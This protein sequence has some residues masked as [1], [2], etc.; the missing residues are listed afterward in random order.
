MRASRA[1][2]VLPVLLVA[3]ACGSS[4]SSGSPP[5]QGASSPPSATP[6]AIAP[7]TPNASSSAAAA[8]CPSPTFLTGAPAVPSYLPKLPEESVFNYLTQGKTRI[9]DLST[10]GRPAVLVKLRDRIVHKLQAAGLTLK[11]EDQEPGHE[12]EAEYGGAHDGHIR[13]RNLCRGYTVQVR[14]VVES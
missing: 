13:I 12:A 3:T 10:T 2:F 6:G 5:S 7:S 14:Y 8:A 1:L 11:G 4:G 9:W